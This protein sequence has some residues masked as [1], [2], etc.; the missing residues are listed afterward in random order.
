MQHES[1]ANYYTSHFNLHRYHH[2]DMDYLDALMPWER[3]VYI[4]LLEDALK[5]EETMRQNEQMKANHQQ[6]QG[7]HGG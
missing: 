7:H 4:K 6:Y 3:D 5:K 2:W 1:L